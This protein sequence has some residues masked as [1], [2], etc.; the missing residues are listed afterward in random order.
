[1]D[2]L[3]A[4]VPVS[5]HSLLP[6]P[7][8]YLRPLP[9]TIPLTPLAAIVPPLLYYLAALFLAPVS[10]S[11]PSPLIKFLTAS[12]RNILALTSLIQFIRLP[13]CYHVPFSVGLTYQLALVGIY[14]ACRV[15]DAF[16]LGPYVLGYL[17]RRIRYHH[18]PRSHSSTPGN[19]TPEPRRTPKRQED[20]ESYFSL[21]FLSN[22]RP[23][24]PIT[25]TATTDNEALDGWTDRA[26]WALELVLSMRGQGFVWTSTD[27]RHTKKT[28]RP[29]VGNRVHSILVHVLPI[30]MASWAVIAYIYTYHLSPLPAF[31]FSSASEASSRPRAFDSL[32]LIPHQVALTMAL[33]A[34]LM[35]AFSLGHSCFAIALSP[36]APH[37]IS[38]FPPLYTNR[39]WDITSVREFWAYGWHRLFS[40]LFLVYGVWPGE[41]LAGK[42]F[43][44]IGPRNGPM[45]A[46]AKDIGK[47]VGGFLSSAFVH[48]FAAWCVSGGNVRDASGEFY[49]FAENGVA[50][51]VEEGVKICVIGLRRRRP[52]QNIEN[53]DGKD[54]AH[55]GQHVTADAKKVKED[56]RK[57]YDPWIGRVWFITVVLFTG[58]NFARGWVGSGLV[59]E[60]AEIGTGGG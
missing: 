31:T 16:F 42:A 20:N 39:A 14:G 46:R 44:F 1:M 22:P 3:S 7:L 51:L 12:L 48:S 2:S 41:W 52:R 60:M 37:P 24:E 19:G 35:A 33:G 59:R 30:L 53:K 8:P 11:P 47:I 57:W 9:S 34:F 13:L 28:W 29:T 5:L 4:I 26:S 36:F 18:A 58:R 54:I 15:N 23:G 21:H 38:F 45:D 49:F 6:H 32:P 56:F 50:V 55:A 40:R 27:V 43:A 10:F 17:P 25:E